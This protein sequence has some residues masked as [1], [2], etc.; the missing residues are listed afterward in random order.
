[1]IVE[2]QHTHESHILSFLNHPKV[3]LYLFVVNFVL[4]RNVSKKIY[5]AIVCMIF[6]SFKNLQII[7][8][9]T[10]FAAICQIMSSRLKEILRHI[11]IY[12][13]K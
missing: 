5:C 10:T 7:F 13:Y 2:Y 9:M 1:M 4:Y 8:F 11:N 12:I 6:L 3:D